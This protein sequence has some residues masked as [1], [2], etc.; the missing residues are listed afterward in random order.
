MKLVIVALVLI[1]SAISSNGQLPTISESELAALQAIFG[2]WNQSTPNVH[3]NLL[4]WNDDNPTNPCSVFPPWKGVLCLQYVDTNFNTT[5]SSNISTNIVVVVALTLD[6]A[7]IVGTLP[8]EIGNL[9]NLVILSLTGNPGLTG[10]IPAEI[11]SLAS[12]QILD[13]HGN[14]FSGNIPDL[15]ALTNLQQLDLSGNQ[16]TGQIPN[17]TWISCLQTLKLSGNQLNSTNSP[18]GLIGLECL[19][20]LNLSMNKFDGPNFLQSM[21]SQPPTLNLTV[22]DLSQNNFNGTLPNMSLFSNYLQQLDL[23]DNLFDSQEVP[24]WLLGF[25]QLQTFQHEIGCGLFGSFPYQ[26]ASLPQLQ[27]LNLDNNNLSG[28]LIID[29]ISGLIIKFPNGS[30]DGHLKYL[31][32]TNNH[33]SN[34]EYTSYDIIEVITIIMLENNSY[35]LGKSLQTD[36]QR[37]YC[38]QNCLIISGDN[39]KKNI[40]VILIST[41]VSGSIVTLVIVITIYLFWRNKR[42]Q[43]YLLL[44]I[45]EKFAEFEVQ[46]TIFGYNELKVA[47]RDFHP[48]MKLGEGSF[49]IVY[50]G[51]L[52]NGI[53]VAI[54]QLLIKNQQNIDEFLNEVVIIS[55]VKHR[56]L[57]KLKGCCLS[58]NKRLLVYEY[59]ENGDLAKVL[60]ERDGVDIS[61]WPTRFNICL[62]IAHGLFYLHEI[63]QPRII[64]RDIKASN[65]LLDKRLQPKIADFGL[66]LLFADDKTH[67]STMH[68]AGT[69]GYLAPE[70][71]TCGQLT[72]KAD[73]Y[74]FGILILEI[75]SGRKCIDNELPPNDT[76]LLEKVWRLHNEGN[77]I[78]IVDQTLHLCND[79][80]IQAR[81]LLNIALLCLLNEGEKRP[82]MAH[83]VAM[84]QG[85]VELERVEN[86][87][88][89]GK[90]VIKSIKT[91]F[92]TIRSTIKLSS[93]SEG[94]ESSSQLLSNDSNI[95][96][97]QNLNLSSME[98]NLVSS[99]QW[100]NNI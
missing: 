87:L 56:N 46:P 73:V 72:I 22:L 34:V 7:S 91:S 78:D 16:L 11:A 4:G 18:E 31:N 51:I 48:T 79:E 70:Y 81:Q 17:M 68:V 74:S 10:P 50:K 25:H 27:S 98:L 24:S 47:T 66:A 86:E 84:L 12:L 95:N 65:I 5:S 55:G 1:S 39:N 99:T 93:T 8:K 64:H 94:L 96:V 9:Q 23:S 57:V 85:E 88:K 26:V 63:A 60:F 82:S 36:G 14:N 97:N 71:A 42:K 37:C 41:L 19:T 2:A 40:E 45:Q 59:L 100:N 32:I 15:S 33:I 29:N 49:G 75:I 80:M 21:F 83:V 58:D 61:F 54:K 62:G 3:E 28:T 52:A 89:L 6:S 76:Y 69:R 77:L 67:I 90:P 38:S 53:E 92:S 44:Q 43:Q 30:N 35:C 20:T 13:L